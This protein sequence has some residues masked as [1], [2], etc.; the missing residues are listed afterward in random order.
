MTFPRLPAANLVP[1]ELQT[2]VETGPGVCS[3]RTNGE[4]GE[5]GFTASAGSVVAACARPTLTTAHSTELAPRISCQISS[6]SAVMEMN[7]FRS[8]GRLPRL[9]TIPTAV[10]VRPQTSSNIVIGYI[11]F[12]PSDAVAK[13]QHKEGGHDGRD[14]GDSPRS[15]A[16]RECRVMP[17][18]KRRAGPP[19]AAPRGSRA[20][21]DSV[22][23]S[24]RNVPA[25]SI[26]DAFLN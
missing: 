4:S 19:D 14:V 25:Y 22:G 6:V 17:F 11:D 10:R 20:R 7:S 18:T 21:F 24:T 12:K 16:A 26:S 23:R 13:R 9:I 3:S 15:S 1:S 8:V 2:S 5:D